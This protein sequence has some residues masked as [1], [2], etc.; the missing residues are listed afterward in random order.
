MTGS[1]KTK[2]AG[3]PTNAVATSEWLDSRK[4][5]GSGRGI[6]I[7]AG[8]TQMFTNA[9]VLVWLLRRVLGCTLSMEIWHLGPSEM[10]SGMRG[11]L[12]DNGATVVDAS[13]VLRRY[14]AQ[15]SD[16][17][18]LK[19]Y[20]LIMSGFREV[21][22]LDADNVPVVD[23]TFL[24]EQPEFARTGAIFWPDALD[25]SE[26]NPIWQEL[27]LPAMQRTSFET[28]QILIDK[29]RH[30]EALKTV[31]HLNEQA[32]RY[33][34]LVYGDKDTF[35]AAWLLAGSQH[36]LVP[37]RPITD[38][39]V[40]YQ[41]DLDGDIVFQH[42]TNAKWRYVGAQARS[43]GFV[44]EAACEEALRELRRTWNGRIFE[45]PTRSPAAIRME[46]LIEGRLFIAARPGEEDRW[47]EL[48]A[49]NQIGRGRDFDYQNWYVVEP[50]PGCY[51]LRIMNLHRVRY[52]LHRK[53]DDHWVE[54]GDAG[55][56]LTA[57]GVADGGGCGQDHVFSFVRDLSRA[58]LA[59]E[60]WTPETAEELRVALA[61]LCKLDPQL[62]NDVSDYAS[63]A[64]DLDDTVRD[65]L[66]GLAAE[67]KR[68]VGEFPR[69]HRLQSNTEMLSDR[70]F[71][72]RP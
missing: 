39:Y 18:Q 30:R 6:V 24:F 47:V 51:V 21:L 70:R 63:G 4:F 66:L 9:W 3:I 62:A 55:T 8:G 71:Y 68:L 58:V 54:P 69:R 50:E 5:W 10:S 36:L 15:I 37:H 32:E 46:Q 28:G 16:G 7:C 59:G 35:L 17:W 31:L 44:H 34:S 61:A 12:E 64:Q 29:S 33:Y 40:T 20:A 19:P 43:E 60:G 14:P 48:L 38:R 25:L 13:A 42:R 41:R 67:L 57:A 49:Y 1:E 56:S 45:P 11:I 53:D 27:E 2:R 22:M 72:V 65:G 23:P 52:E 26:A